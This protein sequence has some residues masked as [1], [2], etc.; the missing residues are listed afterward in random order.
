M[1]GWI[2]H[3]IEVEITDS[4]NA[5]VSLAPP[6]DALGEEVNSDLQN[7]VAKARGGLG[8]LV[9]EIATQS[10][11]L[12]ITSLDSFGSNKTGRLANS[13]TINNSGN[14]ASVGTDLFYASFVEE[15]R[16]SIQASGK[17]LHFYLD[18]EEV[19]VNHVGPST[20]RPYVESSYSALEGRAEQIVSKYMDSLL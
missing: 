4:I 17:A 2:G 9:D 12:Q 19:F 14:S 18:G 1:P 8:G 7:I 13:I 10:R 6:C 11:L 5:K 16:G 15:G 3:N 20:P